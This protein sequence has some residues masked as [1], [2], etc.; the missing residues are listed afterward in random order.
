MTSRHKG[1]KNKDGSM[2]SRNPNV[3]FHEE[4]RPKQTTQGFPTRTKD[5]PQKIGVDEFRTTFAFL[6][7][8]LVLSFNKG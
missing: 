1:T 6:F 5:R 2:F 8:P 4:R 3:V 7:A